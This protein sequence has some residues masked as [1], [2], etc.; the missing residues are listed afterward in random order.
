MAP[1]EEWN[2]LS[3][4]HPRVQACW[5]LEAFAPS[6]ARTFPTQS[7][8]Q[9]RELSARLRRLTT[10]VKSQTVG[11]KL[12]ARGTAGINCKGAQR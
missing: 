10:T 9:D 12:S 7:R 1:V 5:K 11:A 3:P 6:L 2:A 4:Q 8:W